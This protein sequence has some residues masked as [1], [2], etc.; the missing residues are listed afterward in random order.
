LTVS[1]G[2]YL[3][4]QTWQHTRGPAL[5]GWVGYDAAFLADQIASLTTSRSDQKPHRRTQ[6][7]PRRPHRHPM[8]LTIS[9][10]QAKGPGDAFDC[11]LIEHR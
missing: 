4:G 7:P 3:L 9:T 2:L 11:D 5:I 10:E 1:P 6:L 8:M